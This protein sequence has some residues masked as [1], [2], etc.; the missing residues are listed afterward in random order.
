MS[1]TSPLPKTRYC[2]ALTKSRCRFSRENT[3][4]RQ[5]LVELTTGTGLRL[6]HSTGNFE[7]IS[8]GLYLMRR[9]ELPS[10]LWETTKADEWDAD[11]A[12]AF[13]HEHG[14]NALWVKN[15]ALFRQ[16]IPDRRT[17]PLNTRGFGEIQCTCGFWK[18]Q[19]VEA[20]SNP[21]D[22][23]TSETNCR[24]NPAT[25]TPPQRRLRHFNYGTNL[26]SPVLRFCVRSRSFHF[27]CNIFLLIATALCR[28]AKILCFLLMVVFVYE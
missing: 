13:L 3:Q 9:Y 24:L 1:C 26:G 25:R 6:I 17:P 2:F 8:N 5:V 28:F 16:S 27:H 4:R 19:T 23:E 20:V 21:Q 15:G 11:N 10:L 22:L 18:L 12:M 14:H 7:E